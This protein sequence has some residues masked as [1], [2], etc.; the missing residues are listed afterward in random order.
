MQWY[1]FMIIKSFLCHDI[2]QANHVISYGILCHDMSYV[3]TIA[4]PNTQHRNF[5]STTLSH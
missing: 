4:A 3:M 2:K 1:A 5:L